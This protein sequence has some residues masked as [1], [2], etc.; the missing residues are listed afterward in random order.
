MSRSAV[1]REINDW[2]SRIQGNVDEMVQHV[3]RYYPNESVMLEILME[4][5]DDFREL[6]P[7]E[8]VAVRRLKDLGLIVEVDGQFEAS[9]ILELT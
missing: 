3:K 6:A 7:S 8:H 2:K 4:S 9:V 1:L 5:A